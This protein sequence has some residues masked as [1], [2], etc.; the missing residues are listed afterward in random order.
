MVSVD[1]VR[2]WIESDV[3]AGLLARVTEQ[4]Q[5]RVSAEAPPEIVLHYN[6]RNLKLA[7]LTVADLAPIAVEHAQVC[8]FV[9]EKLELLS[10]DEEQKGRHPEDEPDVVLEILPFERNFLNGYLIEL[11]FLRVDPAGLE[12]YLKA[13][14][15][16]GSRK[17]AGQLRRIYRKIAVS[18]AH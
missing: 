8:R 3:Y 7:Q 14:R 17:Y 12:G 9:A 18:A 2:E 5:L 15:I 16:P 13:V 1:S 11:H 6:V 4:L 10:G